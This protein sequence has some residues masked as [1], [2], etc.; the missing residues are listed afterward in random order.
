MPDRAPLPM[1]PLSTVLFPRAVL[2]LRVFEPR[3]SRLIAA[4]RAGDERLG[5]AL[6]ERGSE[7]GGG[8]EAFDVGTIGRLARVG[9][10]EGDTRA[11]LV[12]GLQRISVDSWLDGDPYPRA[13][14]HVR[15]DP[16]PGP[17][18]PLLVEEAERAHRR[19]LA[20]AS[21]LGS[22]VGGFDLPIPA[23]PEAAA[24]VLCAGSPLGQLDRQALLEVNGHEARVGM[25]V[26]ML[27]QEAAVLNAKLAGL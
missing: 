8:E 1:F 18:L 12:V 21:E 7:V 19:L 2:P 17:E 24:W 9:E 10:A 13:R 6:I 25:L 27:N 23:K 14:V 5:I 4:V 15:P 22:D 11:V 26:E 3:Y 20:L 16:P